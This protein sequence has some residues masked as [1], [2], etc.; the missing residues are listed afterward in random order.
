MALYIEQY[1]S[2]LANRHYVLF[3]VVLRSIADCCLILERDIALISL[4]P[5]ETTSLVHDS[6]YHGQEQQT[7]NDGENDPQHW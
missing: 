1:I 7:S 5:R 6:R 4:R 3:S 2:F